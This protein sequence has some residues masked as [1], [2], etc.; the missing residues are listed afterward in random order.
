MIEICVGGLDSVFKIGVFLV[1]TN[2]WSTFFVNGFDQSI[3]GV[4]SSSHDLFLSFIE[5]IL[6]I[7][8]LVLIEQVQ[9]STRQ[10]GA[11]NQIQILSQN[12]LWIAQVTWSNRIKMFQ[13]IIDESL[14][15]FD[16]MEFLSIVLQVIVSLVKSLLEFD[17]L[18]SL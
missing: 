2:I 6:G 17:E 12:V 5:K 15:F 9:L 16:G 3:A 7:I 13:I 4:R 18:L 1:I 11:W 10:L 14:K 8:S